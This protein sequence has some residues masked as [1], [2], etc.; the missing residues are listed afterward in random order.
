[1]IKVSCACKVDEYLGTLESPG[2]SEALAKNKS[3]IWTVSYHPM[4]KQLSVKRIA[5]MQTPLYLFSMD[6]ILVKSVWN[7]LRFE[8]LY[9]ANDD[10]ERYSI[11]THPNLLRNLLVE[12]C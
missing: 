7:N 2:F 10:D 6:T 3:D 12:A 8:L 9:A 1:M 4:K 11:Q 5:E